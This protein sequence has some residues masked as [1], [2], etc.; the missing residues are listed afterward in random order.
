MTLDSQTVIAL[1]TLSGGVVLSWMNTNSRLRALEIQVKQ[2]EKNEDRNSDK[3]DSIIEK[4][5][6]LKTNTAE[7]FTLVHENF[8]DLLKEIAKIK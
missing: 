2:L 1:F 3:F 8:R 4:L 7:K 6:E 5:D